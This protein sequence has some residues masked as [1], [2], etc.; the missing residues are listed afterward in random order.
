[1]TDDD[2]VTAAEVAIGLLTGD[3]AADA[4][5]R[6]A[7]DPSF[8]REIDWWQQRLAPL[9]AQVGD[10]E[11]PSYLRERIDARL[12]VPT[13][14]AHG[15][16][17]GAG[18]KWRLLGLGG[19]LGALAASIVALMIPAT[20][21][22]PTSPAPQVAT[23]TRPLVASLLPTTGSTKQPVTVLLERDAAR[24]RLSA[25]I[26]VPDGRSAQLWRIPAGGAPV[27]LGV[28]SRASQ[29]Y[30]RLQQ[31]NLPAAGDQLAVSIEPVGGSP[32]GQPTGPVIF[33]GVVTTV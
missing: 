16:R 33:A 22:I 11:P 1:M 23:A 7:V 2:R 19:A 26:A 32:T 3:E 5:A 17:A 15:G 27:P 14:G 10:V 28:L 24:L 12:D 13:I 18:A 31:S 20:P 21:P 29:A 4:R 25:S 9:F 30:V 8:A 6:A